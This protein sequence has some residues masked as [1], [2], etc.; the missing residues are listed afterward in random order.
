MCI[1]HS[2]SDSSEVCWGII[3]SERVIGWGPIACFFYCFLFYFADSTVEKS[4]KKEEAIWGAVAM[5][6][7][8]T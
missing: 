3:L 7:I 2:G 1:V 6:V 8:P 4:Q 5:I